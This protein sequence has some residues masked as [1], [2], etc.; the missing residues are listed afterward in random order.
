MPL[1]PVP[2]DSK[3][4]RLRHGQK[5][6]SAGRKLMAS[7]RVCFSPD[8]GTWRSLFGHLVVFKEDT[9]FTETEGGNT[10]ENTTTIRYTPSKWLLKLGLNYD[11]N[12]SLCGMTDCF[13]T[14]RII[15]DDSPIFRLCVQSDLAKI[16]DLFST[17]QASKWDVNYDSKGPLH[18]RI[19]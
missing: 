16:K 2:A 7:N 14:Y 19:S 11:F 3:V 6:H 1:K 4:S 12:V 10:N 17:G 18:V 15:P 8:K 5:Y 13:E 9:S